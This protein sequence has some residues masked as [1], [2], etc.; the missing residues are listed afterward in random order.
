MR[1]FSILGG[2]LIAS[3]LPSSLFSQ[4]VDTLE[5]EVSDAVV[6]QATRLALPQQQSAMSVS[7][8]DET[9][10]RQ[11]Q[12]QLSLNESLDFVPGLYAQNGNNFSQ[13]LRVS[14]RGFGA[15]S[16]FG[17]RGIRVMV[18][19]L[20]ESTPDGQAQVDNI[21]LGILERAEIIRGP[22]SSLYGN[23]AGGVISMTTSPIP[24][25]Y[26]MEAR[27]A[28][29]SN[30][31][32]RYQ[33][34]VGQTIPKKEGE[35]PE[36]GYLLYGSHT[37]LDGYRANSQVENSFFNAKI[38][39]LAD[40]TSELTFLFNYFNSPV[41]QDAGGLTLDEATSDRQQA[42]DRNVSF[43]SGETVQQS[44]AGITWKKLVGTSHLFQARTYV[45]FRDFANALPFGNGGI[46]DLDRAYAG[47]G[48]SYSYHADLGANPYRF[49]VGVDLDQQ[50]D[51]RLRFNNEAGERGDM[52]FD[53]EEKFR[54]LGIYAM[55]DLT[56]DSWRFHLGTRFDAVKLEAM[57]RFSADGNQSG[58]L[59]FN[60][61]S[62]MAGASVALGRNNSL[63]GQV[64]TSFETPTL[65][66]LSANP[67]GEG[68]FNAGLDPQRA[69]NFELGLKGGFSQK[70]RYELA[71]FYIDLQNELVPYELEDFPGRT[72]FRNAGS[73]QR[74]GLEVNLQYAANN[75]L[76]FVATYT[77]SDFVYDSYLTPDGDFNGNRLPAIPQHMGL[78]GANLNLPS[79]FY[80]RAWLRWNS[81]LFADDENE[82]EIEGYS[83][84]NV[85]LGYKKAFKGWSIAPFLGVN[86]LLGTE[87]FDNIRINAF[88]GR[89]YEPAPEELF[90]GGISFSIN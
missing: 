84:L 67:T 21:D 70:F 68:G 51:D 59:S 33:L 88:G 2:I 7:V 63:Y 62:P 80:A 56:V 86:N 73:S 31:F 75:N 9:Q 15:R 74:Q 81:S 8:L 10:L 29:G 48:L 6:L 1:W 5:F 46:V 55:Q 19:G 17:I 42:R 78:I 43:Q 32:Q 50:N 44:R 36:W 18:D 35:G 83:V 27:L 77:F 76:S 64:S 57:D 41:S 23:A 72:F 14:I 13:D 40:S 90:F 65:S 89:H 87:Y 69:V 28:A 47:L 3:L 37:R 20:P 34:K 45:L 38:A 61:F 4:E 52:S 39:Y 24:D 54:S 25:D 79:G 11:G 22:A 85:R 53:Q 71:A 66:E 49:Q 30:G 60:R 82:T 12:Q 16:A 26:N 58:D